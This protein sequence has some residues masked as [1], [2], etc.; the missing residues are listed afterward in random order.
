[1]DQN[2]NENLEALIENQAEPQPEAKAM[3][4]EQLNKIIAARAARA[5]ENATQ[6]ANAEH[7]RELEALRS[8]MNSMGGMQQQNPEDI[9]KQVEENIL[10]NF[11]ARQAQ[12]EQ[13]RK[14]A[15]ARQLADSYFSKME[16][17]IA[18]SDDDIAKD[19]ESVMSD[20]DPSAFPDIV[21]VVAGMD[22]AAQVM[23]E[24]NKSP[25]KLIM[26]DSLAKKSP[27]MAKAQL[28]KLSES[29]NFNESAQK[30]QGK[31]SPPLMH[32]K[33][34]VQAGAD[35]GVKTVSDFKRMSFLKG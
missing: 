19:F 25:N 16:Q 6:K 5:A 30:A 3:S 11:E 26:V 10:R 27:A 17:F 29:I 32:D 24:L 14:I 9:V 31:A 18:N 13:Q 15:E 34:S 22:N 12:E 21:R 23:Y 8:Q 33:S 2:A 20:F 28:A 4:Q 35:D 1:M 7:A